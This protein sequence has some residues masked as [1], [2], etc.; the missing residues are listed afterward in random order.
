MRMPG[1]ANMGRPTRLARLAWAPVD[2]HRRL[3]HL[4]VGGLLAGAILAVTGPPPL[5]LHGPLHYLGIMDP[6]CGMTRGVLWTLRG[7]L[8]RAWAYNPASR[9][10]ADRG[11]GPPRAAVVLAAS[12]VRAARGG[13]LVGQ[14]AAPCGP[15][16]GPLR[17]CASRRS[18]TAA[19][20]A[21]PS[22][23]GP[24]AT[25]QSFIVDRSCQRLAASPRYS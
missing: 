8:D 14:P 6:G 4:A 11:A 12:S 13:G 16:H 24:G 10:L 22:I 5:D 25:E 2:H 20:A 9:P 18:R 3:T 15:A 7:R 21:L 17:G 1:S 19:R 23:A